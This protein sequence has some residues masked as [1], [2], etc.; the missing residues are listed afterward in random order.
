[1]NVR[2]SLLVLGLLL[3]LVSLS[4]EP[5]KPE[6]EIKPQSMLWKISGNGLTKPSYL[7]GTWHLL[8][9]NEIIFKNKVK[10]AIS[11]TEQLM[12]QN[13]ITYLSDEDYFERIE[14]NEEIQQGLPIYKIDDR[15]KRKKLLKLINEHLDLKVDLVKR[16]KYDVKRMTPFEVYFASLHSFIEGCDRLGSFDSLLYNH[17]AKQSAPIGSLNERK[18]F[19]I[20]LQNA[21]FIN[22]DSLIFY[23]ENIE[24][25]KAMAM[26]MKRHYYVDEDLPNLIKQYEIF[27]N[28]EFTNVELVNKYLLSQ[29]VSTWVDAMQMWIGLKPTFISVNATYLL[30]DKGVIQTLRSRGFIVEPIY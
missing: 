14:S 2:I 1:M 7:F 21:N 4:Q 23:L 20:S 5:I 11:Q 22:V 12:M 24:S 15:K 27:I 18:S 28:N 25:Q 10:L 29:D 6:P 8:C 30:G 26:E 3:S 9:R 17:Y 19:L 16:T 13:F